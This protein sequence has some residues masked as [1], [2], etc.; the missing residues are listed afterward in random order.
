MTAPQ[1]LAFLLALPPILD[2]T[3]HPIPRPREAA[4]VIAVVAAEQADPV[5]WAASLD[6]Y[7]ALESG[8]HPKAAGD[9]PGMRAG[10]PL[11]TKALGARSYGAWQTPAA[12]T[13]DDPA[14]QA[15]QWVAIAK[16]S[17]A[18]CPAH[19][20]AMLGTGRCIAWGSRRDALIRAAVATWVEPADG[21]GT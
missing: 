4:S 11:C 14:T 7:A 3:G 20:F 12:T 17:F 19:P 6:T 2:G 15:R 5:F 21:G 18:A 13:S 9:C 1:L 16:R 8:Y 10:S